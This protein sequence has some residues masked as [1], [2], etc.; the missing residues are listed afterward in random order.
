MRWE[1]NE[2][3]IRQEG[4][5][6]VWRVVFARAKL[7]MI[8]SELL[9]LL[10][11]ACA[12]GG[13]SVTGLPPPQS[14]GEFFY[15]ENFSRSVD[16]FSVQSGHLAAIPGSGTMIPFPPLSITADPGGRFLGLIEIQNLIM[17]QVQLVA[18]QPGG[19]LVPGAQ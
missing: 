4:C 10:A 13:R 16:G 11:L 14:G 7:A 5:L 19:T 17:P 15:V 1:Q 18:I 8:A 6:N 3:A 12:G 2:V 9:A